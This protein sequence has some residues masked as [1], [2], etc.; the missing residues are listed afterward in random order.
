MKLLV[1]AETPQTITFA[2]K[3]AEATGG[4]YVLASVGGA[5]NALRA[6]PST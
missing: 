3:W 1:L 4:S 2:Q 6:S 5:T